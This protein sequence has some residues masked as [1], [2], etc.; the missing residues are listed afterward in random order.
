MIN[1]SRDRIKINSLFISLRDIGLALLSA[2]LIL[3]SMPP[4]DFWPLAFMAL[5]PLY[6]AIREAS[7][8]RAA[9]IGWSFGL[10][11][12]VGG[13]FWGI[14]LMEQ[15]AHLSKEMS[16]LNILGVCTY[17]GTVWLVW[18]MFCNFLCSYAHTVS[19]PDI[20]VAQEYSWIHRYL[21][22][23]HRYHA[24]AFCTCGY[25]HICLTQ[26]DSVCG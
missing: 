26:A 3:L 2:A 17:Q 7:V 1:K 4:F 10:A 22:A 5:V 20:F 18:A 24:H 11:V 13:F 19:N 8:L 6:L 12:N 25:Y 14:E 15:F 16:I 23:H 9:L 21:V